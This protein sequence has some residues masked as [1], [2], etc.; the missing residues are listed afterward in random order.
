MRRLSKI[1]RRTLNSGSLLVLFNFIGFLYFLVYYILYGIYDE[2]EVKKEAEEVAREKVV[3]KILKKS[4]VKEVDV[5]YDRVMAE[6]HK[7]EANKR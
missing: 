2:E 5:E 7:I 4:T 3:E 6:V 1:T